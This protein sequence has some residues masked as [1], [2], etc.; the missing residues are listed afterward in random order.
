MSR[1]E[2]NERK[3]NPNNLD[4][5]NRWGT[6]AVLVPTDAGFNAN[7]TPLLPTAILGIT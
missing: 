1:K 5:T 3:F 2:P 4:K 7:L 6:D